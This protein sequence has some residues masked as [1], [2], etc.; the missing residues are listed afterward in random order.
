[1]S[2][3]LCGLL[4][5]EK[6]EIEKLVAGNNGVVVKAFPHA[7]DMT[8]TSIIVVTYPNGCRRPNYLLALALNIPLV[9]IQLPTYF[10]LLTASFVL[11]GS[12]CMDKNLYQ[13]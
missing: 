9:L 8:K 10:I 11:I 2:F 5:E 12:S 7:A 3:I 4:L 1:M 6:R 13:L